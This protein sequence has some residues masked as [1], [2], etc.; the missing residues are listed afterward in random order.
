M[1]DLH[2]AAKCGKKKILLA[3]VAIVLILALCVG[4]V[5]LFVPRDPALTFRGVSVD[6][7]MYAFWFSML[8]TDFMRRHG[9]KSTEDVPAFWSKN[10]DVAGKS[11]GVLLNEE[12][13]EAI[14]LRVV[15]ALLYDELGLQ[16]TT[17]Q[18]KSIQ[19]YYEDMLTYVADG[20]RAKMEELTEKY[21]TSAAAI[22]R[23]AAFDMKA[24]LLYYHLSLENGSGMTAEELISYYSDN[25]SRV[26]IL[27]INNEYK[28]IVDE[29]GVRVETPLTELEQ[30]ANAQQKAAL[31]AYFGSA[32]DDGV[33][34]ATEAIT[35]DIFESYLSGS[36]EGLHA[37][38]VY[39]S[40]LYI[41]RK[42]DLITPG[43]LEEKVFLEAME[44]KEGDFVR[45][46]TE[47][48]VRYLFGYALDTAPYNRTESKV[49]FSNFFEGAASVA[50][51]KRAEGLLDEV[52][53]H[54]ENIA[55]IGV[56]TIPC[57]LE[58][59]LCSMN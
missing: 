15:A 6:G 34:Y 28:A 14:K 7:E 43:L 57:N 31:D 23:C 26:K 47:D 30:A 27:Y 1:K 32:A 11:W 9:L 38:G 56:E 51:T 33:S 25:Y 54:R 21:G 17:S 48:G 16:M 40:G 12:I 42:L 49:F 13:E 53:I 24:D 46:E 22:K 50:L 4:L 29:S 35:A 8:K 36:D 45:V 10:S 58:F 3:S 37:E 55:G 19:Q 39:P 59:K 52:K 20:D 41:T 18:K 2:G 44:M 5:F